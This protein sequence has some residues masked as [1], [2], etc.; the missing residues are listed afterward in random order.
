MTAP[1]LARFTA[2]ITSL[3]ETDKL[4]TG[5]LIS[6]DGLV[7][8]AFH[9]VEPYFDKNQP[10]KVRFAKAT[11]ETKVAVT[12]YVSPR[13]WIDDDLILLQ[14]VGDEIELPAPAPLAAAE[15]SRGHKFS[16]YGFAR[17]GEARARYINGDIEGCVEHDNPAAAP[18]VQ[19][20]CR[21]TQ[22]G[23]SGA[24][25]FDLNADV[26]AVIGVACSRPEEDASLT[27]HAVDARLLVDYL[28]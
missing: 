3:D 18:L 2:E 5:F 26:L 1:D 15:Q 17:F 10:V 28:A 11:S 6:E 23:L 20:D 12:A 21:K 22:R 24:A 27:L 25:V 7:E 4:G 14:V 8:T 9:V 16:T 13:R 19:L